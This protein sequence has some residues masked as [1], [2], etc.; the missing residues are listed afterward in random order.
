M[1]TSS[2]DTDVLLDWILHSMS[3]V[4]R[5]PD[6]DEGLEQNG[7][8]HRIMRDVIL[9][10]PLRG[11]DSSE[12]GEHTGLSNTGIHHQMVK[13]RECGLVSTLVD[14]KWHKHILR[15]GSMASAAS[16]VKAEA[17]A[18]LGIRLKETSDLIENSETRM[19]T[20]SE[21]DSISFQIRIAE[22]GPR[23]EDFD[24]ISTLTT[25]FGLAGETSRSSSKLARDVMEDLCTSH[26][27]KSILALSEKFSESRGKV[28]TVV[29][30]MRS[31][32]FVERVPMVSRLQQDIFSGILRQLDAR[33]E[34]WL[35]TRGGIGRLE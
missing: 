28:S 21:A 10:D 20:E 27:P 9:R 24:Q 7:A 11:W 35:M 17:T 2:R 23:A 34:E 32:G 3:L 8:M 26:Q 29:N 30:R 16:L 5:R 12:I 1:P 15:G 31:A 18:I 4:R 33:G 14:G 6:N 22:P 19:I 25:D 13:L